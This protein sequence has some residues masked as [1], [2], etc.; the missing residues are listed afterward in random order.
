MGAARKCANC[1]WFVRSD[2]DHARRTLSV[3]KPYHVFGECR[4]RAPVVAVTGPL[5]GTD[6]QHPE[7]SANHFCGEWEARRG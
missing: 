5:A 6:R 1:R 3:P 4:R 7:V 2:T